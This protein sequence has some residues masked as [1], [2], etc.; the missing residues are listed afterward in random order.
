[1]ARRKL[2]EQITEADPFLHQ[3]GHFLMGDTQLWA[4]MSTIAHLH[5]IPE[6]LATHRITDESASRSKDVVRS[7]RFSVSCGELGLHLCRKHNLQNK[8][9]AIV[10]EYWLDASMRLALRTRDSKM[11]DEL[12]KKAKWLSWKN[13][14]R[15]L[16]AKY[17]IFYYMWQTAS[18][19]RNLFIK[20]VNKWS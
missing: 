19:I 4:E 20:S 16:S 3:S 9:R 13:H 15:Y 12:L 2:L 7:L 8:T 17:S 10:E 11:A 18:M 5:Y 14:I 1:M 6:S